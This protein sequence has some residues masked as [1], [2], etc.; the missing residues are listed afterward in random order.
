VGYFDHLGFDVAQFEEDFVHFFVEIELHFLR[1]S[2]REV[3]YD[4]LYLRLSLLQAVVQLAREHVE[5]VLG[6]VVLGLV[7]LIL[8]LLTNVV[9][10]AGSPG[11]LHVGDLVPVVVKHDSLVLPPLE[12]VVDVLD[13]LVA[14]V[15][16][17][18]EAHKDLLLSLHELASLV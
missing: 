16:D 18:L 12:Q 14:V 15:V 13:V 17:L 2:D 11:L 6:H 3:V 8:L 4:A 10:C 9:A 5:A 1:K 7:A